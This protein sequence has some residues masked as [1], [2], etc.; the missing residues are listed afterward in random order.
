MQLG[1]HHNRNQ[2][3]EGGAN[4]EPKARQNFALNQ[5]ITSQ[6]PMDPM[7][8]GKQRTEKSEELRLL[9]YLRIYGNT[10][11]ASVWRRLSVISSHWR[12]SNTGILKDERQVATN[13]NHKNDII[14][15]FMPAWNLFIHTNNVR[16]SI[17]PWQ[18]LQGKKQWI[19]RPTWKIMHRWTN[20]RGCRKTFKLAPDLL[21]WGFLENS[22]KTMW[23]FAKKPTKTWRIKKCWYTPLNTKTIQ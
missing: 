18:K 9:Y 5:T 4:F 6:C 7:V 8:M 16:N 13:T 23:L 19:P 10:S 21:W 20:M 11:C 14:T 12:G 17:C 15:T 1:S 3:L 2:S 22:N